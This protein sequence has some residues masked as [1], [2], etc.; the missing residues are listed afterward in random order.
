[1]QPSRPSLSTQSLRIMRAQLRS[2]G[3]RAEPP[4]RACGIDPRILDDPAGR[5]TAE[6]E[7]AF[8]HRFVALTQGRPGFWLRTGTQYRLLAYGP[9]G[10]ALMSA[11]TMRQGLELGLAF[12]DLT[13][14]ESRF[15]VH[16]DEQGRVDG[17]RFVTDAVDP[18]LLDFTIERDLGAV[19][20]FYNDLWQGVFPFT[21][22]ATTLAPAAGREEFAAVLGVP[23]RFGAPETVLRFPPDI[24]ERPMPLGNALLEEVY[25][26]QCRDI[27]ARHAAE[28]DV[29]RRLYDLL[30]RATAGWPSLDDAA[31]SLAMSSR[32]LRRRLAEAGTGFRDVQDR[33]RERKARD[34]LR[35]THLTVE[36]IADCLGYAEGAS[37]AHAFARWT[38]QAPG[39]YRRAAAA[40]AAR[41]V[42]R[43]SARARAA[44][45]PRAP[46]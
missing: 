4:L 41:A 7:F 5:V 12:Q 10:L 30:L 44:R 33:V 43:A 36:Q 35:D 16:H 46:R 8:Q 1:V 13:F 11:S 26:R 29:V 32:T 42:S 19:R 2:L 25:E 17:V 21:H 23:V 34:L 20:T 6:Q 15:A 27:L 18:D 3:V 39:A 45:R 22:A 31:R 40:E 14:T 28:S 9:Y 38:G 24:L 37:F